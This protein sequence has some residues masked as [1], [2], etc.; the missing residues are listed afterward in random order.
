MD[1]TINLTDEQ[2]QEIVDGLT[3][4]FKYFQKQYK[5]AIQEVYKFVRKLFA[6]LW[7]NLKYI[8]EK[9]SKIKK[10]LSIYNRTHNRRIKNKQIKLIR[11]ILLE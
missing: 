9:S 7:E 11:K 8:V 6:Q 2:K 10:C 1:N 5:E 4:A 3:R